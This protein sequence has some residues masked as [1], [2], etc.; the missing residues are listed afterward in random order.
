MHGEL[1]EMRRHVRAPDG[2]GASAGRAGEPA[3]AQWCN[4]AGPG[5]STG[6]KRGTRDEVIVHLSARDVVWIMQRAGRAA[7]QRRGECRGKPCV[8]VLR[9]DDSYTIGDHWGV[10]YG[11]GLRDSREARRGFYYFDCLSHFYATARFFGIAVVY[12]LLTSPV[13]IAESVQ[14]IPGSRTRR[15]SVPARLALGI[16]RRAQ[17]PARRRDFPTSPSRW[18]IISVPHLTSYDQVGSNTEIESLRLCAHAYIIHWKFSESTRL[19]I[20]F[21]FE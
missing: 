19:N 14:F 16:A 12:K 15:P 18:G 13:W 9:V 17:E 11:F 2:S 5:L 21:T 8:P 10:C 6:I 20:K 4:G 7:S 1:S 3:G